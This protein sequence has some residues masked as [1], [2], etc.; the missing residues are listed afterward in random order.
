M[1]NENNRVVLDDENRLSLNF[2]DFNR[3]YG[4]TLKIEQEK[5]EDQFLN[6]EFKIKHIETRYKSAILDIERFNL[7]INHQEPNYT[8]DELAYKCGNVIYPL[9]IFVDEEL[10]IINIENHQDIIMRWETLKN[11]I[12]K[13]EV[14][15]AMQWYLDETEKSIMNINNLKE[16]IRQDLFLSALLTP[17]YTKYI[18]IHNNT[19]LDIAVPMIPHTKPIQFSVKQQVAREYTTFNTIT[20]TQKGRINDTR[21]AYEIATRSII[22]IGD[23]EKAVGNMEVTYQLDK[24]TKIINS[25]IAN[26]N[27]ELSYGESR[28]IEL[29]AFHLEEKES[30]IFD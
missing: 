11:E 19:E 27:I 5:K 21:S 7:R 22:G 15:K 23:G 12:K 18:F 9:R 17:I 29:Q 8:I 14:T 6:F 13:Q 2:S 28:V 10:H 3:Y 1:Y 16:N 20:V 4:I 25:I 26:Y 30:K 24:E